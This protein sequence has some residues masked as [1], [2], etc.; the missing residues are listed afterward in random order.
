MQTVWGLRKIAMMQIW[1]F[2]FWCYGSILLQ[3]CIYPA[4]NSPILW[5]VYGSWVQIL[6]QYSSSGSSLLL[7]PIKWHCLQPVEDKYNE[8]RCWS[9]LAMLTRDN[10][11][12]KGNQCQ[13]ILFS[14]L[15]WANVVKLYPLQNYPLCHIYSPGEYYIL[16]IKDIQDSCVRVGMPCATIFVQ[17]KIF[18][19][20][21]N[22]P[23]LIENQTLLIHKTPSNQKDQGKLK[24]WPS[25]WDELLSDE[26]DV[27]VWMFIFRWYCPREWFY[28]LAA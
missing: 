28:Q 23:L 16:Q 1:Y 14:A 27:A 21:N 17:Y 2:L 8:R 13:D 25:W 6:S 15:V 5:A 11:I 20:E 26:T 19:P 4:L 22:L 9:F 24:I 10:V 12:W 18:L 7:F 3:L